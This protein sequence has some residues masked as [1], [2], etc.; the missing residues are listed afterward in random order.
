MVYINK[1]ELDKFSCILYRNCLINKMSELKH[2]STYRTTE[3]F[4][5]MNKLFDEELYLTKNL[6]VSEL[7]DL[8]TLYNTL[9]LE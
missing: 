8:D 4:E 3:P 6:L 7:I 2:R 5:F 1:E 9:K